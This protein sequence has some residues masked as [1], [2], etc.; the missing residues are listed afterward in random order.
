MTATYPP[1]PRGR[2][3]TGSLR[4]F[5]RDLLGFL[6]RSAAEYGDLVTFR[7]GPR[8]IV[9]VNRPDLIEFVLTT[10]NRH[11]SARTYIKKLLTPTLGM[12]LLTSEG[13]A[14]LRQRRLAQPA[15]HK[16]RINGY[17]ASMVAYADR[18]LAGWRDGETRDLHADMTRL[19]LEIVAKTLFDTEVEEEVNEVGEAVENLMETFVVRFQAAFRFPPWVPTPVNLRIRAN[20][21]RLEKII[22][23]IINERRHSGKDHG[24]LLS[25]LLQASDEQGRMSDRQLRDE[26][27]TLFLAGHETTA[28]ALSWTWYLLAQ[29]PEAE[30]ELLSELDTVLGGRLPALDDL[31]RLRYAEA[32]VTESMRLYPPA[33][34]FGRVVRDEVNLGGYRL[35]VGTT[36]WLCPWVTQRDGRYFE[37]PLAFRPGRWLG[38]KARQLP[39]FAYYPFS[40]GPRTCIGNTFAMMEATLVVAAVAQRFGF[41]LAPGH[42]TKPYP[43]VTLR[44]EGGVWAVLHR[45]PLAA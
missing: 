45:R 40:G 25:M 7:L 14:W 39:R 38:E 4:E 31:P 13:D 5:R 15:F 30:R 43:S 34:G 44:P 8:R 9:L 12:G 17:A 2:F 18:L 6:T 42:A 20:V 3:L 1:G 29:H 11:F 24:D 27:M 26:A 22:Y 35:L 41:T 37:E 16:A 19:T 10:G 21:R 23:R 28:N 33:W 32:V 36:L